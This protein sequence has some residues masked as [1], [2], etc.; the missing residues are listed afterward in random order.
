MI[1]T[2]SLFSH[3]L[4][5]THILLLSISVKNIGITWKC[6]CSLSVQYQVPLFCFLEIPARH[7]LSELGDWE[8][9]ANKLF[10]NSLL[11][12]CIPFS[13]LLL[14]KLQ[15]LPALSTSFYSAMMF[16]IK[17]GWYFQFSHGISYNF[18]RS[19]KRQ[20]Y[21]E[22]LVLPP[23]CYWWL[24]AFSESSTYGGILKIGCNG[25]T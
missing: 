12:N 20:N 4:E 16:T 9:S 7:T 11:S 17:C 23:N 24:P 14:R 22:G 18:S 1:W 6:P 21:N 13:G 15:Y 2:I 3:R 25:L 5:H 8:G 10:Q 19:L